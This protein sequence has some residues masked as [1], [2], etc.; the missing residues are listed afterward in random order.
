MEKSIET[1]YYCGECGSSHTL[2]MAWIN[3]RTGEIDEYIGTRHDE[4]SNFCN[5]CEEHVRIK[6]LLELWEEF[7]EIEVNEDDEIEEPFLLFPEGTPK[8]DVW[9][10]FDERCPNSLAEDLMGE[11]SKFK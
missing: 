4:E 9:H 2:S 1:V 11:T 8:T 5:D 3:N 10:W 7:S 6:N